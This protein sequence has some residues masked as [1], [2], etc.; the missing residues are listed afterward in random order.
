MLNLLLQKEQPS[1]KTRFRA[2]NTAVINHVCTLKTTTCD[3]S[4]FNSTLIFSCKWNLIK[5]L[6]NGPFSHTSQLSWSHFKWSP[7]HSSSFPPNTKAPHKVQLSEMSL[8][9]TAAPQTHCW[10]RVRAD[11]WRR[12]NDATYGN[13]GQFRSTRRDPPNHYFVVCLHGTD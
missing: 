2:L 5:A 12:P 6:I 7:A 9:S 3:H 8:R 10:F 11:T 4:L 1:V 13:R